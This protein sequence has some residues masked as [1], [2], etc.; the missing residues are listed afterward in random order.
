MIAHSFWESSV[1]GREAGNRGKIGFK[2]RLLGKNYITRYH[3][4]LFYIMLPIFIYLLHRDF[5]LSVLEEFL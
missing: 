4:F 5:A 1:E 3:F 2:I